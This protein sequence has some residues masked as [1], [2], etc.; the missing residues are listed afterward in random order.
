MEVLPYALIVVLAFVGMV[1]YWKVKV[2][3]KQEQDRSRGLR[4][5]NRILTVGDFIV[6][7]GAAFVLSI[8]AFALVLKLFG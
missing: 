1:I 3:F 2:K 6:L 5:W 8:G 4:I 7:I